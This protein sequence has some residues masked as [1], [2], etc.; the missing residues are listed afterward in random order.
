MIGTIRRHQTWLWVV[1]ITLTVASFLVFGPTNARMGNIWTQLF[2]GG[3]S[4]FGMISGRAITQAELQNAEKEIE[5]GYFL[6]SGQFPRNETPELRLQAYYRLFIIQKQKDLGIEVDERAAASRAKMMLG[7]ASL[8]DFA[9][10]A[11]KPV[12][13]DA[14]DFD[15][16]LRHQLGMEQLM[17]VTGLHG[18]LVTPQEAEA[19]YR[20]EFRDV[21]TS[22]VMFSSSN[23]LS[24]VKVTPEEISKFYTNEMAIY[25]VPEQ[26]Q[27]SY[28]KF[29]ITNYTSNALATLTNLDQMVNAEAQRLGTNY[30]HGAKT[31]EESK[32]AIR[33]DA[34]RRYSIGFAQ[35]AASAFAM[36]LNTSDPSSMEKLAATNGLKIQTTAPFEREFGPSDVNVSPD[37]ARKAFSLSKDDPFAGP[38]I[39]D[40]THPVD[41]VYVIAFKDRIASR[42]P[43]LREIETKVTSDYRFVHGR[44]MAQEAAVHF[45]SAVTNGMAF[46]KDFSDIC[47][48]ALVKA[49]ELPPFSLTSGSL[50][51]YLQDK[52]TL[53]TLRQIAFQ[54]PPGHIGPPAGTR[55]GAFILYVNKFLPLDEVQMK[56][57]LPAFLAEVRQSREG[58]AFNQWVNAQVRKDAEFS[59]VI[60][61]LNKDAQGSSSSRRPSS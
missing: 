44:Q 24:E 35:R 28:V 57:Q 54:V 15:R 52:L 22:I 29:T 59:Q 33:S 25:R 61:Q 20:A 3:G 53:S 51:E 36:Q 39:P 14:A 19:L 10:K 31:L 1:I 60:N 34:I 58:D 7:A 26:V 47:A 11:L 16:Y 38:I 32:A 42:T 8:D 55:D 41:G 30:Y 13:L 23:Y 17:T 56:A 40:E 46:G 27:V 5:L 18:K 48:E 45:Y 6:R 37:F 43:P 50:P 49:K 21:D 4:G 12:G 9:E 2:G